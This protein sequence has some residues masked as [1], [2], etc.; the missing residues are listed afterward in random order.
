MQHLSYRAPRRAGKA[1]MQMGIGMSQIAP[2]GSWVSPVTTDMVAGQTI[3]LAEL[4]A[5][6]DTLLWL[7]SRPNEAGRTVLVRRGADGQI[8]D[9]TPAPLNVATRVHEYGGG[10]YHARRG[11]VVFSN[12][13]DGAVWLLDEHDTLTQM[14][15]VPGCRYADFRFLLGGRAAICV[16]EDHRPVEAGTAREPVAAIVAI[17]LTGDTPPEANAGKV[18]VIGPDFLSSPRPSPDGRRVAWI[19]WNHPDM[20][21]DAT[22]LYW[23]GLD[24]LT[25]GPPRQIAGMMREAI[26]QPDW[27]PDGIL[28]FCTDRS[29]YW[30][31]YRFI[32]EAARICPMSAEIGGPHWQF[33]Q[34]FFDFLPGGRIVASRITDGLI[35]P[36]E[37]RNNVAQVLPFGQVAEAPVPLPDGGFAYLATPADAPSAIMVA[38]VGAWPEP[39]RRSAEPVLKADDISVGQPVMFP[40]D[41]SKTGHAFL[42]MPVNRRFRAPPEER[43]PMIVICHGGPTGMSTNGFSAKV[44]WWT[45]RGFA[46]L[47]VNYGGSTGFGRAYR[48]R[49]EG[50]WGV[51]D[52]QDCI[53]AA[54]YLAETNEVDSRRIAIRGGSAG[55]FTVL[56][57]LASPG[58]FSAGASHYG[59]A[60]LRLLA[61]DT[62]KFESRYL[63][64]LVGAL[65]KAAAVYEERSPIRNVDRM[66][67][68]V[69]FF[70]G[71]DDKVVP[72]NQARA[73]VQAMRAAGLAAPLY[74]F[75][76]EAHGFRRAE[77]IRRV[78]ELET[79]FYGRVF[80]FTPPGLSE[81]VEM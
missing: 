33:G 79:S 38:R 17:D 70:Q 13:P 72:P 28:H 2:Y 7:E 4:R 3:G 11:R 47:D 51:V 14:V 43:P 26:V 9:L 25:I 1:R 50:Q 60:D 36:I 5:D 23:A 56:A 20:P 27:S 68:P 22:K 69:I 58:K 15:G 30:N 65:P 74:E 32:A 75:A 24:E 64:R 39:L 10:A 80:G 55:G 63:D 44:Q 59:V 37:I 34:R 49:L 16:R 71:L 21:W 76:D 52:V 35:Q 45:S 6:G 41:R 48:E 81:Q 8:T 31:L 73:M 40:A 53:A 78:L 42:Y 46:V 12:K 18:L 67:C 66:H 19:A 57:A 61:G 62:H 29:G 54:R 77:T